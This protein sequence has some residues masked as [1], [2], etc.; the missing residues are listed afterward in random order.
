MATFAVLL[1]GIATTT[2]QARDARAQRKFA[3]QQATKAKEQRAIAE[4]PTLT[5]AR[6]MM[7][8]LMVLTE[9]FDKADEIFQVILDQNIKTCGRY[10]VRTTVS[11]MDVAKVHE[12]NIELDQAVS[13]VEEVIKIRTTHHGIEHSTVTSAQEVLKA[14]QDSKAEN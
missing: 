3:E 6:T 12:R 9:K 11:S 5:A 8:D 14:I 10:D 4:H 1:A 2:W 7:A 13:L